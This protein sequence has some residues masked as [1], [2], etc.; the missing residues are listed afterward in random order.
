MVKVSCTLAA[1]AIS[2]SVWFCFFADWVCTALW[3]RFQS[4][5][6]W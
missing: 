1:A 6:C 5:L 3:W 4:G 2:S